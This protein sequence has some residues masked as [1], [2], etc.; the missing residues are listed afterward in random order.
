MIILFISVL[1]ITSPSK[2]H[3][4]SYSFNNFSNNWTYDD[5]ADADMANLRTNYKTVEFSR[6]VKSTEI[7]GK[8]LCFRSKNIFF[9]VYM[10]GNSIYQFYPDVPLIFGR[11]YGSYIHCISI[12]EFS[13]DSTITIKAEPIYNDSSCCF[14]NVFAGNSDLYMKNEFNSNMPKFLICF[15]MFTV[16]MILI[17]I[18]LTFKKYRTKNVEMISLG[19]FAMLV[20]CWTATETMIP[21]LFT[22][23][24][25]AIHFLNYLSFFFM[26]Y[27]AASFIANVSGN[28]KSFLMRIVSI[29]VILNTSINISFTLIGIADYHI[30][31][32]FT[33]L[34]LLFSI[35]S[36]VY[37]TINSFIHNKVERK[38]YSVLGLSF[39]MVTITGLIDL[40]RYRIARST[41]DTGLFLRIGLFFFIII[42]GTYTLK[43][44]LALS[45][46]GMKA[47]LMQKLAYNDAL[48]G[49]L[50]RMAFVEYEK[51]IAIQ[52]DGKIIFVQF[53]INNLKKVND[54]Y[55][56]SEGD[57]HIIAAANVISQS[58]GING[59]SYR[60]GGDEFIAVIS[61]KK[62]E[63]Y[64]EIAKVK[65][66]E[67]INKYN[68]EYTPPVKLEIAY[69]FSIYDC[70]SKNPEVAEREADSKMYEIKRNMKA[71]QN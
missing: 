40:I 47:E 68:M 39:I 28:S 44:L 37:L 51:E 41:T 26:P 4:E 69:G 57:K 56:H 20:A 3:D 29:L 17:I 31:L 13:K 6:Q 54:V 5:G 2:I 14:K 61:G 46:I 22:S 36:A 67:L 53:D 50:N 55:G 52:S 19:V 42:L 16:G 30:L 48:T 34:I 18:G 21:Q 43:D 65:F 9:S 12:P 49:M 27:P 70:S 1:L 64:F 66:I 15:M 59:K 33:H 58:F 7:S 35:I 10:N 62:Y 32:N 38:L 23:A 11:S 45:K 71:A 24:P 60:T 8:S 63:E 25:A